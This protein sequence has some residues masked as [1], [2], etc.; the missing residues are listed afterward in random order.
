MQVAIAPYTNHKHEHDH[1]HVYS[2]IEL[3]VLRD[4]TRTTSLRNAFA[5]QMLKRFAKLRALITKAIVEE[6]VFG[7]NEATIITFQ[8]PGIR[9]FQFLRSAEKVNAF[10]EWL[11]TEINNEILQVSQFSQV[12]TGIEAAWSNQYIS[13]SYRRGVNRARVQLRQGKFGVPTMDESGGLDLSLSSP[14]HVD[15]LGLLYSRTFNEL[16]GIT[17][18]MD[19]TISR[20]LTLGIADGSNPKVIAR[21]LNHAIKGS[22][23]T[24]D[25]PISYINPR[26]KRLVQY[27]MPAERRAVIMART[28]IIRA[29][30]EAQLQEYKNW[31][32]EGVTV[33]AEWITAGD[34]RVC[35]QCA[36]LEGSVFTIEEATNKIPLHAQCRCA[37]IPYKDTGAVEA[38]SDQYRWNP[39]SDQVPVLQS[40]LKK[41]NISATNKMIF[42][43]KSSIDIIG[44]N[45]ERVFSKFKRLQKESYNVTVKLSKAEWVQGDL[46]VVGRYSRYNV[47]PEHY[48]Y[49]QRT[50][51]ISRYAQVRVKDSF[52][53]AS[54]GVGN[55]IGTTIRHEF[56][57]HIFYR[58]LEGRERQIWADLF[59]SKG[60][61]AVDFKVVSDYATTNASEAF[62]ESFA[63]YSSPLY[64]EG[65]PEK[66]IQ[67]F[68]TYLK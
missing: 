29:H 22:G 23:S 67:F 32:V 37:W 63:A 44:R 60:S 25:L 45:M 61:K 1:I 8:T 58:T 57:H 47:T 26:T 4:P 12:G 35:N 51:S 7:L 16:R 11:R 49:D 31:G 19:Q 14:F 55:D 43:H 65:L 46:G 15:R 9:R 10:M 20:V 39:A 13:D 41:F 36:D 24:L 53:L 50:I 33:K 52:A 28:E 40:E 21:M 66:V 30:A 54:D 62:A 48:L 42:D 6:D 59:Y 64:R 27:T 17:N 56:G 5:R 34:N 2:E 3:N 38:L 18:A 68:D